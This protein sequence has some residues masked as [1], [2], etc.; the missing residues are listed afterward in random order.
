MK[1]TIL[2]CSLFAAQMIMMPAFAIPSG[3]YTQSCTNI[4]Q[5]GRD[6]VAKCKNTRGQWVSTTLADYLSCRPGQIDNINGSL[7]C[8]RR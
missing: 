8:E 4:R 3:S 2:V 7:F 6:L 1:R 5:K